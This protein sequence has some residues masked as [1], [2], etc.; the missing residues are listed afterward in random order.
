MNNI[1]Y[2]KEF[3]KTIEGMPDKP[4]LLLHVCCAPCSTYCLTQ[5][6][7]HFDVTM[8]YLNDNI[9][10]EAEWDK[11]LE[12]VKR[13][14]EIVNNGQ[15]DVKPS[16]PLKLIVKPYDSNA[17]DNGAGK[18]GAMPE[19]GIRCNSCIADRLLQSVNYAKQN[20]F[21]YVT[22]TLTVSPYKNAQFINQTGQRLA[23]DNWLCTDFKKRNGYTKS[24]QLSQ[25]YKLYRQH[26]CGC[27]YSLADSEGANNV[28]GK[29]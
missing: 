3:T 15:F 6:V 13:L 19:G 12:E 28:T 27:N 23:P 24:I 11:R 5:L 2:D 10:P 7:E 21:R 25:K 9:Q 22:T 8:L 14:V 26:Y 16:F 17:F 1:N 4:T 18:L 20:N 29:S